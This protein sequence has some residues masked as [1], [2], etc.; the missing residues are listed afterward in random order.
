MNNELFALAAAH[1]V[2][3]ARTLG[4]SMGEYHGRD[5]DARGLAFTVCGGKR[6]NG[7]PAPDWL[8]SLNG[9]DAYEIAVE[10]LK[11]KAVRRVGRWGW[12]IVSL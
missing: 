8:A 1:S 4:L 7:E 11:R 10:A 5:D 2:R 6:T 9:C 3:I 12:A